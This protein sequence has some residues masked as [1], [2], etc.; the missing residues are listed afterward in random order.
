MS[1]NSKGPLN[2]QCRMVDNELYVFE[3]N[4]RFSGTS[5]FRTLFGFN[6]ADI[7]VTKMN[8]GKSSFDK[9]KVKI[10]CFGVRGFQ[11]KVYRNEVKS[12][13]IKNDP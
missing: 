13:I 12:M 8:E 3:I 1:I 6:E 9:S 11:E 2:I 5:P 7:L 4:P 10:G